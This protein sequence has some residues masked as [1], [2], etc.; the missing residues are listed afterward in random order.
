[1]QPVKIVIRDMPNSPALED[2]IR[3]KAEKLTQY[4]DHINTCHIVIEVPQKHKRQG[5]LFNVR[6]DLTVPGKELVVNHKLDEDVY[7]AI[8][9]AFD[10]VLR[11]LE[12]YRGK[13]RGD[14][15]THE[16]VNAGYISKLFTD[17]GYGFIQS[18]DGNEYYFNLATPEP[19]QTHFADL[20]RG[21]MVHFFGGIAD[22][23]FIAHHI[24]KNRKNN[25]TE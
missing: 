18:I 3:K 14:V 17:E 20:Q 4:Y 15:K 8:R 21:D 22:D 7:V 16:S 10:A 2:H 23:G 24:T 19:T 9:D 13:R 1:M 6:I 25:H 11:K 5:K 12:T